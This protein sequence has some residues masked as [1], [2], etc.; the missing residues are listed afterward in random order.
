M[1][2]VLLMMLAAFPALLFAQT[3]D[4]FT[5][6]GKVGSLNAPA[7]AYLVYERSG[8]NIT[9]STTIVNGEFKFHGNVTEPASGFVVISPAGLSIAD[10]Q[11]SREVIDAKDLFIEKANIVLTPADS[12]VK[13]DITGSKLNDDNKRLK[14]LT[15]PFALRAKAI[16]D[17]FK[18]LSDAE[19]INPNIQDAM[20]AK[21]KVIQDEETAALKKFITDN[22]QSYI[23][24]TVIRTLIRSGMSIMAT[25]SYYNAL[26]PAVKQTELGK[27]F[28]SAIN[29]LKVTEI[30][31]P[32]PLFT[33]SDTSGNPVS[34]ASFKGKYV[35]IDFWASWCG[36]CRQENPHVVR[37]Y[38]HYKGKNFTILG[39]SLDKATDKDKW[40]K[41]IKDDGLLWTQVSDL[42]YWENEASTLYKVSFIPQNFLI[43]PTG[44]II[45]KNLKGAELDAKLTEI[46]KM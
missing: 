32:A 25:E 45:A 3:P 9:D 2:K 22:P 17:E 12:V 8:K 21:Y 42:K 19:Q 29:E 1:K 46:F 39:V 28:G 27:G 40:L 26:S 14:A 13:A 18:T 20:Q 10:L 31:Q 24:L 35:L 5:I 36:P 15:V 23:S 30:G 37:V 4:N 7:R 16:G 11:K 41:A 33:Q 6:K 38:N 44:K 43:D 34:L